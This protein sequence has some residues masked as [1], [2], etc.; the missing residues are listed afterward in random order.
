MIRFNGVSKEFAPDDFGIKSVSF[1]IEPGEFVFITGPSGS[2]KTTLMRLLIREYAITAGEIT[3]FD[4]IVNTLNKNSVPMLRRRIGVVFQ[5]YKLLPELNVWE[6]IALPLQIIGQDEAEIERRVT[7]LLKLI[8][9]PEK[10]YLFPSQLSGGEAQRVGIA[11]A[12]ATGPEVIFADEPTGN[13][14]AKNSTGIVKLLKKI[15]ELGTTILF[16]THDQ[17][18]LEEKEFRTLILDSGS[19]IK[20]T[21]PKQPKT[22]EKKKEDVKPEKPAPKK[23]AEKPVEKKIEKKEEKKDQKE[24]KEEKPIKP[25]FS[26]SKFFGKFKKKTEPE[27]KDA[28]E[29]KPKKEDKKKPEKE[30]KKKPKVEVEN[31]E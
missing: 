7:D 18:L 12:L 5:D 2:G 30:T 21:N 13:L 1:L 22:I 25:A 24:K 16:A 31:L 10:A 6:N 14:D 15:N 11:R 4:T 17:D 20:D 26:I 27:K 3:F 9:L 29:E 19:L 23:K 28:V 8:G